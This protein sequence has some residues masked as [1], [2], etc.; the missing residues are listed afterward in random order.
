MEISWG[1]EGCLSPEDISMCIYG[2]SPSCIS[3]AR[4]SCMHP[5]ISAIGPM[6]EI[7]SVVASVAAEFTSGASGGSPPKGNIIRIAISQGSEKR[8]N[9]RK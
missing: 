9:R 3:D 4:L 7:E 5:F 2:L 6:V 8:M 1:F